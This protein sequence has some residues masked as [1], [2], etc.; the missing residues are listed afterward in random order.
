VNDLDAE[1][2]TGI[3]FS[4]GEEPRS[5]AIVRAIVTRRPIASTAQLAEVVRSAVPTREEKK[6]LARVFQA[7]RIAVNTELEA[8]EVLLDAATRRMRRGGR[9]AVIAY[10][11]LEDRRAKR[12]LRAGNL[13]GVAPRDVF[14]R[15]SVPWRLVTRHA[16]E[17]SAAEVASNPR[18]RSARLRI[19][20]RTDQMSSPDPRDGGE[21]GGA[22]AGR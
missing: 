18:A 14:G 21:R 13:E 8:L 12:Y 5:R 11:S 1:D 7:L 4:H 17:A 16:V 9:I 6:T 20:E 10:H 22:G 15:T 3:L 2:L 19:A